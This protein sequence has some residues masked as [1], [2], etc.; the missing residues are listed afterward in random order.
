MNAASVS[1]DKNWG[2][3]IFGLILVVLG[4]FALGGVVAVTLASVV[5]FGVLL[6]IG[7][8]VI[9]IDSFRL[10]RIKVGSFFLHILTAIFY[11]VIGYLLVRAPL[12][13]AASITLFLGIFLLA[14]GVCRALSALIG[15][16]PYWGLQL[17]GGLLSCILGILI[18]MHWPSSSLVVIGLFIGIELLL[19]GWTYIAIALSPRTPHPLVP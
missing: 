11:L 6:M 17:A 7:G 12:F 5:L 16:L 3:V 19:T 10:W 9:F 2:F 4:L 15:R 8:I 13:G 14:V 1:T 18:L